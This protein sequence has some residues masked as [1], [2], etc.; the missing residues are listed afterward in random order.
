MEGHAEGHTDGHADGHA[1]DHPDGHSDGI[2][3]GVSDGA[4]ELPVGAALCVGAVVGAG[5]FPKLPSLSSKQAVL[6]ESYRS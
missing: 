3:D 1:D 2:V 6:S 4:P 5:I